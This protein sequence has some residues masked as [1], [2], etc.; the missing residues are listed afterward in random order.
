MLSQGKRVLVVKSDKDIR[1][2][3]TEV[4]THDGIRLACVPVATLE[5]LQLQHPHEYQ[6]AQVLAVDEAQFFPDLTKGVLQA[7]EQHGK[8]VL[9]AGLDG[10]AH[11][12]FSSSLNKQS[13]DWLGD[14][15]DAPYLEQ[16]AFVL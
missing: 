11:G 10:G 6:Q 1:Y 13:P 16:A 15:L 4:V 5:Q 8:S 2:S 3:S 7:V 9:V 14:M 12:W